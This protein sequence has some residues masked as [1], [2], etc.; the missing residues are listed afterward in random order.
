MFGK[1]ELLE[2]LGKGGMA[3]VY[4]ARVAGPLGISRFVALKRMLSDLPPERG[5]SMFVDEM[6]LAVR[7]SHPNIIQVYD[8]GLEGEA[9]YLAMEFVEGRDVHQ[10]LKYAS[11]KQP[12]AIDV[13]SALYIIAQVARGLD[14]AHRLTGPDGRAAQIVHRDVSPANIMVTYSG[15]VKLADFGIARAAQHLRVTNTEAGEI[16]GKIRYMSPEQA[17]GEPVDYRTDI[18]ALGIVLLELITLAPAFAAESDIASL[19]RVQEGV[20]KDWE[21]KRRVIPPDVVAIIETAMAVEKEKRFGSGEQ[22]ASSCEL[23]LRRR[24]PGFGPA[25][26]AAY[27]HSM[28][29]REHADWRNRMAA[30]ERQPAGGAENVDGDNTAAFAPRTPSKPGAS[31]AIPRDRTAPVI[32]MGPATG[33][34]SPHI[35]RPPSPSGPQQQIRGPSQEMRSPSHEMRSPSQQLAS[36]ALASGG[37]P[38]PVPVLPAPLTPIGAGQLQHPMMTVQVRSRT[39]YTWLAVFGAAALIFA[40]VFFKLPQTQPQPVAQ[41]PQQPIAQPPPQQPIAPPQQ[42]V[43]QP[44]AVP[45]TARPGRLVLTTNAMATRVFLDAS[46]TQKSPIPVAAGGMS[47]KVDVPSGT[48]WTLRVEAD[49][50]KPVSLPLVVGPGEE[51]TMPVVMTP[52]THHNSSG[53]RPSKKEDSR[54]AQQ[55]PPSQQQPTNPNIVNPF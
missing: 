11:R 7:L 5:E 43:T 51:T 9:Y 12:P 26:L 54:P 32:E 42:P 13:E 4:L 47:F 25:Q 1:Y 8:F 55:Q 46:P 45:P 21:F 10:I 14:C 23:A 2:R 20:P 19:L 50:F 40:V 41:P 24:N 31:A 39:V 16:K 18:F 34:S 28:F 3:E 38:L 22:M 15:D 48:V 17:R 6:R 27:M 29:S 49:G 52:E 36:V 35:V 53:G 37:T 33:P 44:V 30:Y